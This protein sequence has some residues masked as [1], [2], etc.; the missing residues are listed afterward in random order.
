[1]HLRP[2]NLEGH[3][4]LAHVPFSKKIKG[5]VRAVPGNTHV[6]FED[7]IALTV[8]NWSVL[9]ARCTR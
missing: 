4:T 6:K 5:R 7:R 8:L 3:V 2:K 1:M 9:T